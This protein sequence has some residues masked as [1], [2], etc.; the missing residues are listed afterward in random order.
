MQAI[1][2]VQ[3][4]MFRAYDIRGIVDEGL[5]VDSVYTIGLAFGSE[6]KAQGEHTVIIARDGRLSGPVLLDALAKGLQASGCDVI[7][8][9]AVPT[10]VLYFATHELNANSGIMLTGSHNPANYNGLKMILNGHT[11]AEETI[12][13]LYRRLQAADFTQGAGSYRE[14]DIADDYVNRIV[15]DLSLKKSLKIVVDAGNGIAGELAP[16]LYRALGVEVIE[17]FCDVDG[18]FPNHHPDPSQPDNLN[19]LINSVAEHNADFGLAFDGD[20]DR[21]G[22]VTNK[23]EIIWPDRQLMLYA[24]DVLARN[25][26]AE[27][28]YDVKCTRHLAPVIEQHGGK[29]LM[30]KTGHSLVKAKM[31]QSGALLAGEMSGHMFFKE[32]W[33]GFDD[34]LYTGARLC[35]IL[36][37][38]NDSASEVFANIPDSISTP[39]LKIH[40]DESAKFPFME[41]LKQQANFS[42]ANVITIDG[43]RVDF[44]DG[45]GLIRPSNTTP[46]L[47]LRFEADHHE[48]LKRIQEMFREQ[49]SAVD[50]SLELPF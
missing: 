34:G 29:P 45:W 9:G 8:I 1:K 14:Q 36:S 11:L 13:D 21:L 50:A 32:R 46:C 24:Q 41:Q 31:K 19:D 48:G 33:Y 40:I 30:W 42:D 49:I 37:A 17:L 35:E 23:G 2:N 28:I 44:N 7:N 18:T 3:Q 4:E 38:R 5:T 47:V 27:I 6:A 10:P 39:E 20:G 12:Q 43:L 16:T 22:V 26:Q 15:S 25:P